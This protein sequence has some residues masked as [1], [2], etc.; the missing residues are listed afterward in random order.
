MFYLVGLG[1]P[2]NKYSLTRHN[3]G[4]IILDGYFKRLK[5]K[6]WIYDKKIN[7]L[8]SE[9]QIEK[10][11]VMLLLPET[12]MN[13]SGK[14]LSKIIA[15]KNKARNLIVIHDDLDLPLGKFKIVFNRGSPGHKGVESVIRAVKTKE[16][17]RIRVGISPK[18]PSG[19]IRPVRKKFSNGVKK[20]DAKKILDFLMADFKPQETEIIKKISPK[21]FE[22]LNLIFNGELEKAMNKFN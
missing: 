9:M 11:K 13:N 17:A 21:I 7:A 16:F 22:A 1:N 19:K 12:F 3:V 10:K 2:G 20:P 5:V 8:K 6:E 4:R 18:I 14:A 15:S